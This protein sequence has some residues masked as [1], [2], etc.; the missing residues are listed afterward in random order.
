MA[1]R[2]EKEVAKRSQRKYGVSVSN[3]TTALELA[4]RALKVG[5]GDEVLCPDLTWPSPAHVIA[6]CGAKPVLLDVDA[7]EWNLGAET[8]KS[9]ITAQT[10]AAIVIDQFGVPARMDEIQRVLG[11]I[12]IIEDAAC[13]LGSYA[14]EQACG[15]RGLIA[16][17]SFHPRKIITTGE[18]GMC[19]TDDQTLARRLRTLRNHGMSEPGVFTEPSGNDRMDELS[20]AVGVAQL[21]RLDEIISTRTELATRYFEALPQLNWQACPEGYRRNF[22]TLGF[23]LDEHSPLDRDQLIAKL[24]SHGIEASVLSYALHRLPSLGLAQSRELE[25]RYQH[26]ARIVDRGVAL[27]LYSGL[28]TEQQNLVIDALK[29]LLN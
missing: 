11:D 27:P 10:K 16:T 9:A 3:G 7:Q 22:Q 26:S 18:G 19:L 20:A 2:F 5:P 28:S 29:E 6:G 4:L 24:K 21:G 13:A 1:E 8:I 25:R 14:Q 17:F 23:V 12:P 15:S